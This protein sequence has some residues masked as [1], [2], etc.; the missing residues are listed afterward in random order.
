[1]YEAPA[2]KGPGCGSTLP[3]PGASSAKMGS[4]GA[5]ILVKAGVAAGPVLTLAG[6]DPKVTVS[7]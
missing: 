1:M 7:E 4:A 6:P 2:G 3:H 5:A